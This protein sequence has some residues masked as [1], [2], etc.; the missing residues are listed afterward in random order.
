MCHFAAKVSGVVPF[1]VPV[2]AESQYV[3][4]KPNSFDSARAI[5]QVKQ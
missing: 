4:W 2:E 3:I 1:E 5:V